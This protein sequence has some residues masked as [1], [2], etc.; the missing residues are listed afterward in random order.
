[1]R[2]DHNGRKTDLPRAPGV[3]YN[4]GLTYDQ[5]PI[6]ADLT[7]QYVGRQLISLTSYNLDMYLQPVQQ[8]NLNVSYRW[9]RFNL[10]FQASNLLDD[11]LFY[12]TFG[13]SKAYLGTQ[14][15]GGNGS[16]VKTGPMLRA[17]VGY[18]L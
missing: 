5:G 10:G 8:L 11:P 6:S 3:M 2:A 12:K 17:T 18:A 14:S 13:K 4:L 1:M 7:Y 15:G 9:D 16:Y